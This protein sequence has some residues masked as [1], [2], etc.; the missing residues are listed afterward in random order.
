LKQK[1]LESCFNLKHNFGPSIATMELMLKLVLKKFGELMNKNFF[2]ATMLTL[3]TNSSYAY[4]ECRDVRYGYHG[5]Y[6]GGYEV[7]EEKKSNTQIGT[8]VASGVASAGSGINAILKYS[9][10]GRIDD[11]YTETPFSSEKNK[12]NINTRSVLQ[13]TEN[14]TD[15]DRVVIHYN[16]SEQKNRQH[17]IDLM[18]SNA[19]GLHAQSASHLISAA[20]ATKAEYRTNAEG[21]REYVGQVPDHAMRA[22]HAIQAVNTKNQAHEYERKADDARRGGPVP[23]YDFETEIRDKTGT[24]AKTQGIISAEFEDGGK[25]FKV[26]R[27]PRQHFEAMKSLYKK[28]HFAFAGAAAAAVIG[29]NEYVNGTVANSLDSTAEKLKKATEENEERPSINRPSYQKNTPMRQT[30]E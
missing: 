8:S 6:N 27:L 14:F 3:L 24:K 13:T 7:C 1:F 20:T 28:G 18:E 25:V 10:G 30:L 19:S 26:T 29:V 11:K 2:I 23:I 17:H 5:G 16:L 22:Y 15:G 21:K 4:M 12:S 9:A